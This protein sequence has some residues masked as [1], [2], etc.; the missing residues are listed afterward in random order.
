MPHYTIIPRFNDKGRLRACS[1]GPLWELLVENGFPAQEPDSSEFNFK[2][3]PTLYSI[4]VPMV[5]KN[6]QD[7]YSTC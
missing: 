4:E 6:G 1:K 2:G 3:W 5:V 7:D